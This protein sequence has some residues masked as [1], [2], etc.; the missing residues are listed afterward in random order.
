MIKNIIFYP[1]KGSRGVGL[2]RMNNH[3]DEFKTYLKK[4][5]KI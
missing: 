5:I 2:G 1:K 4:L 3:G